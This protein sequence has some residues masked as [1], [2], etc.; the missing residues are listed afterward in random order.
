MQFR[1]HSEINE[2]LEHFHLKESHTISLF[3]IS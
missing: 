1:I 3:D 2:I